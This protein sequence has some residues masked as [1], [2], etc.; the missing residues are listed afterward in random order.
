MKNQNEPHV[1]RRYKREEV[2]GAEFIKVPLFLFHGEFADL[3]SNARILYGLLLSRLELSIENN[4]YNENGELYLC[5]T[6][7]EMR[8]MLKVSNKTALNAVKALKEHSLLNEVRQGL[9]KPNILYLSQLKI[10]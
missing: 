7:D 5:Y 1:N 10:L 9:G 8:D 6:R 4:W 2:E 3:D